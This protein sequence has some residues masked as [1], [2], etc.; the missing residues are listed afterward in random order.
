MKNASHL[1]AISKF[2]VI[3]CKLVSW[4]LV[5]RFTRND[6]RMVLSETCLTYSFCP[7][8]L[9]ILLLWLQTICW[10]NP[11]ILC[12]FLFCE[13]FL[14]WWHLLVLLMNIATNSTRILTQLSHLQCSIVLFVF[15]SCSCTILVCMYV[16]IFS[17]MPFRTSFCIVSLMFF[18]SILI[19]NTISMNIYSPVLPLYVGISHLTIVG[20]NDKNE[21]I[22]RHAINVLWT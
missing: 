22:H 4:W 13:F 3:R 20:W 6:W 19:S 5:T 14:K 21:A 1:L 11:G 7:I 2:F 8:L 18:N 9:L 15:G 12:F 10:L 16:D 17:F